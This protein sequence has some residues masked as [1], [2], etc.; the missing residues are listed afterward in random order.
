LFFLWFLSGYWENGVNMMMNA[1]SRGT[2][3][4]STEADI[5]S[6]SQLQQDWFEEGSVYGFRPDTQEQLR[7][8]LGPFCLV[9][10]MD[11][12]I[13][14]FATGSIHLSDGNAVI[15]AGES[16]FEVDNVFVSLKHRQQGIGGRLVDELLAEAKRQEV[17]FALLYSATKDVHS[18]LKFYEQHGFQSWFVQMFQAL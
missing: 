2:I 1:M 3:R 8:L 5:F 18:I 17:S 16:Y 14:G 15:P 9:A 6:I 12:S 13:I 11:N 7:L 10:E 4:Q